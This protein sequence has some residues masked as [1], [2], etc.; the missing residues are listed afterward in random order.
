MPL[1]RDGNPL[2]VLNSSTDFVVEIAFIVTI[3]MRIS[4]LVC[5]ID[6]TTF[7]VRI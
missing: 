5:G 3:P 2:C 6:V 7:D 1:M 4:V